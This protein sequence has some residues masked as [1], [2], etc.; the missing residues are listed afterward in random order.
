M[1]IIYFCS[2][3]WEEGDPVC[4]LLFGPLLVLG[5]EECLVSVSSIWVLG[6]TLKG[7]VDFLRSFLHDH[8]S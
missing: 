5:V 1:K 4:T 2:M 8:R 6:C 3:V 7:C